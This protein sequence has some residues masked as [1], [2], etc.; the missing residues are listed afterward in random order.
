VTLSLGGNEDL[1]VGIRIND[2]DKFW[3]GVLF[4]GYNETVQTA[5]EAQNT[6]PASQ[7]T[8]GTYRV[9]GSRCSMS[10]VIETLGP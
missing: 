4:G 3:G 2:V 6:I 9:T 8:S 7:I 1:T 5:C 10:I